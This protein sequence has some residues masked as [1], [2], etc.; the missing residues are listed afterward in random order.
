MALIEDLVVVPREQGKGIG[1]KLIEKLIQKAASLNCYKT[2]LNSTEKNS[3]FYRK[4][5]FKKEQF[6][7]TYRH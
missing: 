5:E 4:L 1:K 7:F 3:G 6:Q 2:I